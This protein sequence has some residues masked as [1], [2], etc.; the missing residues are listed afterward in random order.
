MERVALFVV[1]PPCAGKTTLVRSMLGFDD[2]R[3][4]ELVL[5]TSPKW[6]LAFGGRVVAAGHYRGETFDG[7]DRVPYSGA[8][9]ALEY[10]AGCLVHRA[11]ITIFD[12][13]RF[14][15]AGVVEFVRR[16]VSRVEVTHVT[17]DEATLAARRAARGWAPNG[18]WLK[19]RVTKAA[20]FAERFG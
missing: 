15:D 6:T 11:E 19:G 4:R 12:G 1:G 10:W 18:A 13:D 20:R 7:A 17:A 5:V 9:A 14:A 8:R 2:G 3:V 16:H